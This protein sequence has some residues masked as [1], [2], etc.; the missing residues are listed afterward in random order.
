[1]VSI[2]VPRYDALAFKLE[3]I[4]VDKK[5]GE[6]MHRFFTGFNVR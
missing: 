3:L 5:Q 4:E 2:D 1:M 6:A